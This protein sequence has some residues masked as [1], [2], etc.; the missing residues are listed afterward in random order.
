MTDLRE[1]QRLDD[2][3]QRAYRFIS[4][5]DRTVS[6]VR[7]RL[8]KAEVDESTA[9]AAIDELTQLGYLDDARYAQRF[10]ED[11]RNLDSWGDDRIDRR[12]RE[13]GVDR[14]EIQAA[15]ADRGDAPSELDTAVA[16]LR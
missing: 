16:L 13:L 8:E 9:Q 15:L 10:A 4:K 1:A 7:S 5:R 11:R 3:L 12:L 14:G 2:A 6:E